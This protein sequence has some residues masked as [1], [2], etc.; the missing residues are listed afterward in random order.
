MR[1]SLPPGLCALHG[2]TAIRKESTFSVLYRRGA[3]R[4]FPRLACFP[5]LKTSNGLV[6]SGLVKSADWIN[7]YI[8]LMLIVFVTFHCKVECTHIFDSKRTIPPSAGKSFSEN[9]KLK[10]FPGEDPRTPISNGLHFAPAV[11]HPLRRQYL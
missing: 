4:D 2:K 3:P 10:K 7:L 5:P 11:G 1:A 8:P 6:K 9:V